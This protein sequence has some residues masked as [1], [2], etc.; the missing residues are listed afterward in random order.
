MAGLRHSVGW[1]FKAGGRQPTDSTDVNARL[2]NDDIRVV[3]ASAI[4]GGST[5]STDTAVAAAADA[6]AAAASTD[7]D[8]TSDTI[9]LDTTLVNSYV[10]NGDV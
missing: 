1:F 6:A 2:P 10:N 3:A 5:S 7:D 9:P 4:A 8:T